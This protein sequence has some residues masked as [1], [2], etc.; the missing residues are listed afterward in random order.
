MRNEGDNIFRERNSG[1]KLILDV[2][3]EGQG[4]F[5]RFD[6]GLAGMS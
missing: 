1:A 2:T 3:R 6:I 5:G 4:C